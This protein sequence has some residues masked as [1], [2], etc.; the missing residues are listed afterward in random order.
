MSYHP[1]MSAQTNHQP[2]RVRL[3]ALTRLKLIHQKI[4]AGQAPTVA[5]IAKAVERS[6]RTIKR[7]LQFMRDQ[8]GAP[9]LFDR[10]RGGWR[11]SQPGWNLPPVTLGHGELLAFFTAEQILRASG[12][13]P[14]AALLRD[15]LA[16]LATYLPEYIS[17][18][19][20]TLGENLSF[21]G[22]PHVAVAPEVLQM[23]GR[24]AGERLTVAFDYY[25][26]HRNQQTHREADVLL[27]RNFAGDWYAIAF[28]HLR[29]EIRDFHAGRIRNLKITQ[30]YFDV[31]ANWNAE[32]YL[33]RG[34]SMMRGGR[35]TQVVVT[36]D[37]YQ[38]RWMR[39]RNNFHPDE[40][41]E[42]LPDG[43]LRLSFPVGRNGLE[44]VARFCLTYAGHCV[45]EK[46]AALRKLI[47]ERL[48]RALEQHK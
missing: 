9:I 13:V 23:L 43:R 4:N 5:E 19:L 2:C 29:G 39:E 48:Q 25:S 46:P 35:K 33:R 11:F 31:P 42:D 18:D 47:R 12:H 44:A 36:F 1:H 38:S 7:D 14:E 37:A 8:L 17:C 22:V 24:A 21:E 40:V 15:G 16:K 26:Q 3:S 41:R 28:D 27:L 30:K 34:F 45:V 20:N 10:R 6:E 32:G